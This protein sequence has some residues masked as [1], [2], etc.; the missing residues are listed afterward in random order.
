L[1]C[2]D[3]LFLLFLPRIQKFIPFL[4]GGFV[5]AFCSGCGAQMVDGATVCAACGKAQS[6][7]GGAAAAPATSAT[8]S[9]LNDNVAGLLAYLFIPA[10]IFLVVERFSKNKFVRFHAFQGLF[11]GLTSIVGHTV[12][13]FIP[14]LGWI[15]L[16]FFSLA[17]F[18]IAVIAAIK[19]FQNQKWQIP[20]I[21][22]LAQ[23]Q[24]DQ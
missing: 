15:I 1:L 2:V 6:V 8:T 13:T 10:I 19:A 3:S 9:G 5:M 23:K 21:G 18:I 17:I 7:G 14:V 12:L 24:A 22:P 16:P 11:L 4:T 20:V